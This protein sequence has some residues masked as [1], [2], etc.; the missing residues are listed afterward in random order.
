MSLSLFLQYATVA[1]AVVASAWVVASKQFPGGVRRLRVAL[2][3]PLVR[4]GRAGWLRHLGR[5]IAPPAIAG[6]DNCGGCDNCGPK[7]HS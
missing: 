1:L 2:A 6:S 7:P 3:V 4:D 5:I